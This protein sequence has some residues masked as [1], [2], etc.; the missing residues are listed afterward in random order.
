M[1]API[2]VAMPAAVA[3]ILEVAA[4]LARRVAVAAETFDRTIEPPFGVLDTLVAAAAPV[5]RLR[6]G[7]RGTTQQHKRGKTDAPKKRFHP[8]RLVLPMVGRADSLR[9]LAP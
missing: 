8:H 1:A 9:A 6:L 7:R 3:C 2:V 5:P 4:G